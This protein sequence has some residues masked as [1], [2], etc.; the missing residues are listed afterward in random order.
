MARVFAID[1][2]VP[3]VE[4]T[5]FVHPTAVLIGDVIVGPGAYVGPCASLRGDFGR[6]VVGPGAN[7]Q[8][9]CTL[10]SFPG[11]D[12]TVEADGHVGHGAVLHGALVGRNALVGMNAVLMDGVVVG[13]SAFVAALAFV[14]GGFEVPPGMLA[15]GLPARL[16]R[17]L[18]DEEIAWKRKGTAEYQELARRCRASLVETTPLAAPEPD[19]RRLA[20]SGVVPLWEVKRG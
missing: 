5:A 10:H 4:P 14:K 12:C 19:R 7:V 18:T 9:S 2:I 15:A 1:G 17:A 6:I 16:V 20:A 3:V 13:E 8:D 11:Q